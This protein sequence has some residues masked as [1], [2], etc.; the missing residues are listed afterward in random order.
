MKKDRTLCPGCRL[1][2]A[3]KMAEKDLETD[4]NEV[5]EWIEVQNKNGEDNISICQVE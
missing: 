2:K 5:G 3:V 4:S 1:K